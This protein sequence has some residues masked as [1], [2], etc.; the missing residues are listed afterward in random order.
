MQTFY[1][2]Y[3]ELKDLEYKY[4]ELINGITENKAV[5]TTYIR[6]EKLYKTS[7]IE[8]ITEKK[9]EYV[10]RLRKIQGIIRFIDTLIFYPSSDLELL[11]ALLIVKERLNGKTIAVK[12]KEYRLSHRRYKEL[13]KIAIDFIEYNLINNGIIETYF[14]R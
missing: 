5:D 6:C 7:S 4:I 13:E 2:Y 10:E 3:R 8:V 11:L 14:K 9:E 1:D 12:K